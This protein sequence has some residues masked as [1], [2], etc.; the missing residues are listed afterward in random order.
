MELPIVPSSMVYGTPYSSKFYGLWN[1]LQFQVPWFMELPTV[2]SSMV[3]G[4]PYSTSTLFRVEENIKYLFMF[5]IEYRKKMLRLC[6]VYHC[7]VYNHARM[8]ILMN[9]VSNYAH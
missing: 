5:F 2:P 3:Y 7:I 8:Y 4:T 6:T 1:S 9:S